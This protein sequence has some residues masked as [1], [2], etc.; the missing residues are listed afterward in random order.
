M[1]WLSLHEARS[2]ARVTIVSANV[3]F[4]SLLVSN[5]CVTG[6]RIART[7]HTHVGTFISM[8][9]FDCCQTVQAYACFGRLDGELAV[10]IRWNSN[11]ELA[12][13]LSTSKRLRYRF[14]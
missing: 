4:I 8:G 10:H 14:A 12:A 3:F 11:H 1:E 5:E 2:T 7:V 9:E 6:A 13:E